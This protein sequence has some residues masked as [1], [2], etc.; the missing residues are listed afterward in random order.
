[1]DKSKIAALLGSL[2]GKAGTGKAKKRSA[3]HYA[4][5]V[6]IRLAKKKSKG[7]S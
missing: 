7:K 6:K 1:M 2:G 3:A 4:R 5:M